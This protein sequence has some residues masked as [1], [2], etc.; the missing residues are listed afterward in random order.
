MCCAYIYIEHYVCQ[1]TECELVF[2]QCLA[3]KFS[4]DIMVLFVLHLVCVGSHK[5][6]NL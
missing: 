1:N 6:D 4:C 5:L 3:H 2:D